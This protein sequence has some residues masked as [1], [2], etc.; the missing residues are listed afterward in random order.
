MNRMKW[1]FLLVAGV[2]LCLQPSRDSAD[3]RSGRQTAAPQYDPEGRLKLP[4]GFETWVFVG[5]NIG[6][7]YRENLA[8]TTPREK[9]RRAAAT[10]GD[11]HN[12]YINPEAY[13]HYRDTGKFPEKTVLIMDVYEAKDKEPRDIVKGG[14]FPG[15]RRSIEVAVKNSNR[16]DKSKT[17]WAYYAFEHPDRPEP[18]KAFKDDE[19]YA[20]H[21]QHAAD[22]NVWV[23]FYPTL[24]RGHKNPGE[25]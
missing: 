14:F 24:L 10:I 13:K 20:C 9:K 7:E 19:C 1:L 12:V 5:S 18:A 17:D 15:A 11:F 6:L 25:K 22:D 23:Q 16:P 21:K 4:E 3:D 2:T 8:A